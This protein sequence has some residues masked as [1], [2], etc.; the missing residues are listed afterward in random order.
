MHVKSATNANKLLKRRKEKEI[1][2][3]IDKYKGK[4][5]M[6]KHVHKKSVS[7]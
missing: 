6:R 2:K 3:K 7:H 4:G 1:Y 5:N